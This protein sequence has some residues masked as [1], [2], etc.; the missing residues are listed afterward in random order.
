MNKT[1]YRQYDDRWGNLPYPGS[2]SYLSDSGCGCLAVYHCAIELD[3]Y[4]SLTVPQCRNYMVQFATVD[5]G[6]LWSGITAGLE[7][8]GFKVH[9][10]EADSMIDI[11][12]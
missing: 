5:N 7:H 2:G 8:Y 11:L 10:R 6:T 3:K 1:I 12:L 9:W 4:K